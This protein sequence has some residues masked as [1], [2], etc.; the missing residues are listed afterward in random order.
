MAAVNN[1][2]SHQNQRRRVALFKSG[3]GKPG[4]VLSKT[5]SLFHKIWLETRLALTFNQILG[6]VATYE[7]FQTSMPV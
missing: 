2:L 4:P 5:I 3:V 7:H 6:G 1:S